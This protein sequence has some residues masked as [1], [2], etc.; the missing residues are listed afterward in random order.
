M[1]M[2][3]ALSAEVEKRVCPV[4]RARIWIASYYGS[5]GA[6]ARHT[7]VMSCHVQHGARVAA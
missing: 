3:H 6:R 1:I 2:P 5:R 4:I 7:Y